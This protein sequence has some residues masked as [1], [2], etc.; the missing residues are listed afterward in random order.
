MGADFFRLEA[1][2]ESRPR[3]LNPVLV[4]GDSKEKIVLDFGGFYD[5]FRR[6]LSL[7][8]TKV[9]MKLDPLVKVYV[10]LSFDSIFD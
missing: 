8:L 2:R 3:I 5:V 10:F 6:L 1:Q 9:G 4:E 7:L